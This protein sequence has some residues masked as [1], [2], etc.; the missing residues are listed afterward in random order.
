MQS[1]VQG[2]RIKLKPRCAEFQR[3]CAFHFATLWLSRIC[4]TVRINILDTAKMLHKYVHENNF[5]LTLQVT[6]RPNCSTSVKNKTIGLKWNRYAKPQVIKLR[7][8]TY[9]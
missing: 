9:P 5:V 8:N 1:S 2:Q 4:A 6:L 3:P 7:L